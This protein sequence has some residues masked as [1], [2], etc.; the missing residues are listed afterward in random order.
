[1]YRGMILTLQKINNDG[2][3]I[4]ASNVNAEHTVGMIPKG[5]IP[6]IE[7]LMYDLENYCVQLERID[8]KQLTKSMW[9]TIDS[10]HHIS[11]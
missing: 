6:H 2:I 11:I 7:P 1:M 3:A 10:L 4:I 8:C 5:M 9:I